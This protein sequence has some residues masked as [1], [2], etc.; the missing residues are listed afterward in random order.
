M[1]TRHERMSD[2]AGNE[3]NARLLKELMAR[4]D[5]R[6]CA[7]CR[8]KD[9]RWAS[10][11]I[12]VFFC[13][14]CSGFHRSMGTHISKVKSADL[15]SW[16]EE[17]LASM[18]RWGNGKAAQYWEHDLPP[19]FT[20][21]EHTIDQFI[22]AKYERKQYAMKGPIPDP[23][24]LKATDGAAGAPATTVP[25][26][27]TSPPMA[28]LSKQGSVAAVPQAQFANFAAVPTAA[29]ASAPVATPAPAKPT[30]APV[31]TA[32]DQ[33]FEA[34]SG[35]QPQ[36][37]TVSPQAQQ[38]QQGALKNSILS[39]YGNASTT[40]SSPMSAS[41][42]SGSFGSF[43]GFA[44]PV[45]YQAP[46]Q[47]PF[48]PPTQQPPQGFG[49]QQQQQQHGFGSFGSAAPQQQF[50]APASFNAFASPSN[51]APPSKPQADPFGFASPS[52][53]A[54]Q[55]SQPV[56]SPMQQQF[57]ASKANSGLGGIPDFAGF[58]GSFAAAP[59]SH[60][61]PPPPPASDDWG[62]FN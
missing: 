18:A 61:A 13:I 37:A 30:V 4:P 48:H 32:S 2:K 40:A 60:A 26:T 28:R 58:S 12:G 24:T 25:A 10:W 42:A 33:L 29:A 46:S 20:P 54:P 36:Q 14:R 53:M 59:V 17:Q 16:T 51:A 35:G 34:F 41:G 38:Q 47:Q 55:Q 39:L 3:R 31:Q 23:D 45:S 9:P 1:T 57:S 44:Q 22:R 52:P 62:A 19:N 5:N 43:A 15:D 6:R 49:Q 8:K 50:Q 21:P 56:L 11:N 27:R 7:D